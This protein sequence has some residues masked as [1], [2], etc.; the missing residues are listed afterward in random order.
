MSS[1]SEEEFVIYRPSPSSRRGKSLPFSE[2]LQLGKPVPVSSPLSKTRLRTPA[3]SRSVTPAAASSQVRNPPATSSQ[4]AISSGGFD[5]DIFP[6]NHFSPLAPQSLHSAMPHYSTGN[7]PIAGPSSTPRYRTDNDQIAR[8]SSRGRQSAASG[9][10]EA[11]PLYGT[12][13]S[14]GGSQ[15][16]SDVSND[17]LRLRRLEN[18]VQAFFSSFRPADLGNGVPPLLQAAHS[19]SLKQLSEP[20]DIAGLDEQDVEKTGLSSVLATRSHASFEKHR[21]EAARPM[22]TKT[23]KTVKHN[24]IMVN[25]FNV[26]YYVCADLSLRRTLGRNSN[27]CWVFQRIMRFLTRQGKGIVPRKRTSTPSPLEGTPALR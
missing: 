11:S 18:M 25:I 19:H 24:D 4:T 21:Q 15:Q 10:R 23:K 9:S 16:R 1:S 27:I 14:L 5:I 22:P 8:P 17:E 7:D 26:G 12:D 20:R 6:P 3:L 2:R 13:G